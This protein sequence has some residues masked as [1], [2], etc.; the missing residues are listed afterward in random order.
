[1]LERSQQDGMDARR[2]RACVDIFGNDGL[3]AL[4][5]RARRDAERQVS[6]GNEPRQQAGGA[7]WYEIGEE[8]GI[9]DVLPPIVFLNVAMLDGAIFDVRHPLQSPDR[10][11]VLGR[12]PCSEV[13]I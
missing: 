8:I 6:E 11:G 10:C 13:I 1:M 9:H 3:T 2:Y 7:R 4:A 12:V 5:E